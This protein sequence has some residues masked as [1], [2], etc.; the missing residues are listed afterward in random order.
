MGFGATFPELF[1]QL[2]SISHSGA[3]CHTLLTKYKTSYFSLYS[4]YDRY[5]TTILMCLDGKPYTIL[6]YVVDSVDETAEM[7]TRAHN[8]AVHILPSC[9]KTPILLQLY[10]YKQSLTNFIKLTNL[11]LL[12]I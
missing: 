4:L 8:K 1:G 10:T 11:E 3:L 7:E 5:L 9:N 12:Y 2:T 6:H